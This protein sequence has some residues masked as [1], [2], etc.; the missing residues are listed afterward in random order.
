MPKKKSN[1][2]AELQIEARFRLLIWLVI[3]SFFFGLIVL[4]VKSP[5]G[6]ALFSGSVFKER[7]A[8][9]GR[10]G[11]VLLNVNGVIQFGA[12]RGML[13][14]ENYG[15][16]YLIDKINYY[17]KEKK[18]KGMILRIN[19][20]GGTIGAVQELYNAVLNFRKENKYVIASMADIAASGGYYI[21]TACD[22]I[23][24]NP[25]TITGSIGVIIMAPSFKG[26]FN[27]IGIDYNV[28][29]SGKHKDILSSHRDV[30]DQEKKII[31]S[32]VDD[33]YSQFYTAVKK[34]R[35]IRDE[36]LKVYADGRIFTGAQA[37][38]LKLIDGI[39]DLNTVIRI[40]GEKTGLGEEPDILRDRISPIEK[41]LSKLDK[42]ESLAEKIFD[43]YSRQNLNLFYLH[44][45]IM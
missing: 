17:A 33:A 9:V 37:K 38:E 32:V 19:S 6:G 25:G 2:K 11:I 36:K 45:P 21:A 22:E 8:S 13:G 5:E 15:V 40:I 41:F 26:L 30:T 1:N 44:M 29:K 35:K 20:P 27:K 16:A 10:G 23:F 28:F 31:G 18:I 24:A 14:I 42:K 12:S 7:R 43:L 34:A 4:F 3:I 39:G